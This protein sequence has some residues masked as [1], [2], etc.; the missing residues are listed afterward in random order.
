MPR[1]ALQHPPDD[2]ESENAMSSRNRNQGEGERIM[3]GQATNRSSSS[4]FVKFAV[5]AAMTAI[6]CIGSVSAQE[7]TGARM[8][9]AARLASVNLADLEAAF[10]ACE[11]AATTRGA[12][13]IAPCTAVYDALKE[14]KFGGDFDGLLKWWQQNKVSEYRRLGAEESQ[15]DRER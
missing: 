4:A 10:W 1:R 8:P 3:F 14:R 5:S 6:G 11:Y 13:S 9:A 12:A 7:P 15:A 2:E